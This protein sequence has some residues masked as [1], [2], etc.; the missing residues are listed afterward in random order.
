MLSPPASCP[1]SYVNW[2]VKLNHVK[3]VKTALFFSL[4]LVFLI[5]INYLI[6]LIVQSC[7]YKSGIAAKS[8]DLYIYHLSSFES[9]HRAGYSFMDFNAKRISSIHLA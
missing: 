8:F 4:A 7:C 1:E 6:C 3:K 5:W 9:G 2:A